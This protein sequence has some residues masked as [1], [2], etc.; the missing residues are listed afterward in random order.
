VR[1]WISTFLRSPAALMVIGGVATLVI[2]IVVV[3]LLWRTGGAKAVSD[4]AAVIG[5]LVALG[6]V[7]TAQMVSIAL[8]DQR[9]Q[10]ARDLEAQRVREAALQNYF[11]EVG[12]LLIEKP[13]RRASPGDNLSTVVRAQTLSVLEGLDPERKRILLQF[14]YESGL[15]YERKLV[16]SLVAANLNEVSLFKA[17][18]KGVNLSRANLSKANLSHADLNGANLSDANLSDANL[19]KAS[20]SEANL[21]PILIGTNLIGANLGEAYLSYAELSYANLHGADLSAAN[22]SSANL[23]W[24]GAVRTDLSKA[25]LKWAN[26]RTANLEEADLSEADLSE[27]DLSGAD[28]SKANLIG[29]Y[30]SGA[31]LSGAEMSETVGLTDEQIAA[32]KSLEGATMPNGQKYEEWIKSTDR[33]E[34]GEN[35]SP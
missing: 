2:F 3:M 6:G 20:L 26:L 31:N 1:R 8:E 14:L 15:I 10:E 33:V 16:V 21:G 30:L 27:A 35:S 24:A 34:D 28:L 12:E 13:L 25:N 29:A 19:S 23:T 9:T 4:N 17:N 7:F 32:A 5:A 18:L 11:E 22:L